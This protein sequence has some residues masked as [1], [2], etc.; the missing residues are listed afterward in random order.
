MR[1]RLLAGTRDFGQILFRASK[2]E[3]GGREGRLSANA[4]VAELRRSAAGAA[5][6]GD[7][8]AVLRPAGDVVA[9]GDRTFLA[10]GDGLQAV[11]RRRPCE[12]RKSRV[13][14]ARRAPSA[15]LYSRVPRSSAWPS[16]TMA[17]CR[18]WF[19]HCAWRDSVCCA[20]ARIEVESVSK[21]MRSPTL[22]VKSWAEPGVAAP[23]P[24]RPRSAALFGVFFEAQPAMASDRHQRDHDRVAWQVLR[25]GACRLSF[26]FE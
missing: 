8:A 23:A 17:Y 26:A 12:T 4:C 3:K 14:A 24:L 20:S 10:V 19:S 22:T 7:G 2:H 13:A 11:G 6:R 15:R 25:C 21:K 18:Y 5:E 16:T 1:P 9:D